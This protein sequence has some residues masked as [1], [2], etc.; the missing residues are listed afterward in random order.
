MIILL[1]L[2]KREIDET[3]QHV[4]K[5][6]VLKSVVRW[7]LKLAYKLEQTFFEL[8]LKKSTRLDIKVLGAAVVFLAAPLC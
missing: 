5:V 6:E 2:S 3:N 1:P 7:N 4:V 8:F